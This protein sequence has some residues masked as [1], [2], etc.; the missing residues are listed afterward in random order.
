MNF[1]WDAQKAAKNLK[2]HGVDFADAVS[3]FED[4]MGLTIK[5]HHVEGEERF[6]T[7]GM[8]LFGRLLV[9]IYTYRGDSIRIIS[10][11]KTTKNERQIYEQKRRT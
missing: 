7:A 9:V 2:K 6:A 10:A 3:V 5:E 8:D 11:R 4:E 1:Q